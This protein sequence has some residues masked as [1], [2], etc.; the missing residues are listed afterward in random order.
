MTL[1]QF[2][3]QAWVEDAVND[4]TSEGEVVV[5]TYRETGVVVLH[6]GSAGDVRA[7]EKGSFPG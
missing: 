6:G 5:E 3:G 1:K 4:E 2:A 7:P